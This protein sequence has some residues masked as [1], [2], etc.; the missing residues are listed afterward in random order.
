VSYL[1]G[2]LKRNP[3]PEMRQEALYELAYWLRED[4][5]DALFGLPQGMSNRLDLLEIVLADP[6][7][8]VRRVLVRAFDRSKEDRSNLGPDRR[9]QIQK[10]V[11]S[12]K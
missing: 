12:V 10:L 5:R 6:S 4:N 8:Q 1:L 2:I 7:P 9:A 3:K 11:D